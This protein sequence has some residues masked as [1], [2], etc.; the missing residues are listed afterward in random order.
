LPIAKIANATAISLEV[1]R[2]VYAEFDNGVVID[3]C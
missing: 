1:A 2:V 3:S